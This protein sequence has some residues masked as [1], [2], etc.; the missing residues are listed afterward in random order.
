MVGNHQTSI[1]KTGCL[2]FQVAINK[3]KS[4]DIWSKT[5]LHHDIISWQVP[6]AKYSSQFRR[7]PLIYLWLAPLPGNSH[8]QNDIK[9]FG[10]PQIKPTHLPRLHPGKGGHTQYTLD[11]QGHLLRFGMDEREKHT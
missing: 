7:G 5:I 3:H 9:F 4:F 8:H 10:D 11:I 1:K 2:E 6:I